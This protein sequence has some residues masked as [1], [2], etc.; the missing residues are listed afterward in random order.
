MDLLR[1]NKVVTRKEHRC[2]GCGRK[3]P[4]GSKMLFSVYADCGT[5]YNSYLCETCEE[6]TDQFAS[7]NH[8]YVEFSEGDFS[9]IALEYEQEN[10]IK[11]TS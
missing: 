4:K 9:D 3:F 10:N 11:Q 8:G 2:F 1:E 7:E 6:I 5:A